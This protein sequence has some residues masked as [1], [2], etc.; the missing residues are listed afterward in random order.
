MFNSKERKKRRL[1]SETYDTISETKYN[2][3]LGAMLL[4]GFLMNVVLVKVAT[5]FILSMN[6][7]VFL[8]GYFIMALVGSIIVVKSHNPVWSF[9]GYN[10]ICIPIGAV[11]AICI[12]KYDSN[13]I[14]SAIIVT[15]LVTLI[16]MVLGIIFASFFKKLG[17]V[18]LISLLVGIIF[19]S[20][21][22]LLGY[23]GDIFNWL[24]VVIFSLY[25]GYDWS[26]AQQ[27]P[28]TVDNAID[29]AVDLYL[30]ITNLFLRI[31]ELLKKKD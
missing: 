9:I 18:L 5:N 30:D 23:G 4:Y 11:F 27:Y 13:L 29:S 22:M 7:L 6:P 17:L 19:E 14:I 21:A 3:I 28:K 10:L 24:F 8:I 1:N 2:M 12:P 16:M 25:I 26:K 20:I 31:L 15:A